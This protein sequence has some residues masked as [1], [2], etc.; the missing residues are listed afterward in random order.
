MPRKFKQHRHD[1]MML[2][3]TDLWKV[4]QQSSCKTHDR[5]K[6]YGKQVVNE[7][8]RCEQAGVEWY[9]CLV[10]RFDFQPGDAMRV[11][12]SGVTQILEFP[13]SWFFF[14]SRNYLFFISCCL[15]FFSSS[16]S[17][18]TLS[19]LVRLALTKT[20]YLGTSPP[21]MSQFYLTTLGTKI[22]IN[23]TTIEGAKL[24]GCMKNTNYVPIQKLNL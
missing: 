6:F 19:L 9:V 10:V 12:F 8:P 4:F 5:C 21:T 2:R 22:N 13:V 20:C 3:F 7:S 14:G 17:H 24:M 11:A 15:C 1:F 18:E 16:S 23:I